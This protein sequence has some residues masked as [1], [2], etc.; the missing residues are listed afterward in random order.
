MTE[1]G[2]YPAAAVATFAHHSEAEAAVKQLGLAGFDI[3]QLSLIGKGYHTDEQVTGFYN[4]G[5][6]ILLWGSRGAF[7]GAM[8]SLFFGGLFLTAPLV[9]PIVALGY[10]GLVVIG[11]VEG[12]T[13]V[14]GVSAI[15]AAL[16][17]IGIPKDS[18][19]QYETAISTDAFLVM[20]HDTPERVALA[21]QILETA[22]AAQIDVHEG[23]VAKPAEPVPVAAE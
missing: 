18:V 13:L 12:A 22:G 10:V 1:T 14:G 9:G 19:L 7:W 23:L 15:A 5:D 3:T 17:G 2:T 4:K 8:W 6:R 11:V 16:Y 21:R 20:A